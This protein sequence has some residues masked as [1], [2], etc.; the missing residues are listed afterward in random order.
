MRRTKARPSS[1]LRARWGAIMAVE[2]AKRQRRLLYLY[3]RL[4]SAWT[5]QRGLGGFNEVCGEPLAGRQ[6]PERESPAVSMP[7]ADR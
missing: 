4:A 7:R 2:T 3:A 5:H 1:R 6:S